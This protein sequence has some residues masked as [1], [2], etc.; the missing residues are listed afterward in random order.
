MRNGVFEV[1]GAALR[2]APLPVVPAAGAEDRGTYHARPSI[3]I[4]RRIGAPWAEF[5]GVHM[6]FLRNPGGPSIP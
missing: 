4:A 6:E 5:P 1:D 3:E 2:A